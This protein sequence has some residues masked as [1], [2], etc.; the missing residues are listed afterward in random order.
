[1]SKNKILISIVVVILILVGGY[2][3]INKPSV[4]NNSGDVANTS[5][6]VPAPDGSGS[7]VAEMIVVD[8][9]TETAPAEVEATSGV[10]EFNVTG[11][12]FEFSLK[13]IKVKTGDKVKITFTN[14][15]G[16]HDFILDEFGVNTGQITAGQS[17]TV[18]FTANQTGTFEYY[19]S[20]G[21]H[22]ANGMFG[23]LIVE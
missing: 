19:C 17:R 1:M 15:E 8:E 18:E 21:Q 20:V 16:F 3:L 7:P 12:N 11:K 13:E 6:A 23:K 2:Y 9:N 22:R 14:N 5:L 10:K 4:S